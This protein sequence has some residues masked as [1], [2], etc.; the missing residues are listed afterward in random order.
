MEEKS[1]KKFLIDIPIIG[2]TNFATP[3]ANGVKTFLSVI[4]H[5]SMVILSFILCY[6]AILPWKLLWNGSKLTRFL[7]L[8]KVGLEVP[9]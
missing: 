4:Y 7:T 6:K 2:L 5:H 1:R 9:W 8:E 3:A